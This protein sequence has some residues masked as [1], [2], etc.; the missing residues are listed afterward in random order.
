VRA[1]LRRHGVHGREVALFA[2][3]VVL[4][5]GETEALALPLWA[6]ACDLDLEDENIAVVQAGGKTAIPELAAILEDLGIPCYVIADGDAH[7]RSPS[8]A[9]ANR[10]LLTRAG[11]PTE[12]YPATVVH[13]RLAL[14]TESYERELDA[15]LGDYGYYEQ[16]A[17]SELGAKVGKGILARACAE[18]LISRGT[19]PACM[20]HVVRRVNDLRDS[21]RASAPSDE[22]FADD[23]PL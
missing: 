16:Q 23:F 9:E 22:P 8:S 5:E 19:I 18:D 21:R 12:D 11:L 17:R 20:R 14:W 2:D 6:A 1:R 10:R 15:E 7:N 4:V 13:E 3:V